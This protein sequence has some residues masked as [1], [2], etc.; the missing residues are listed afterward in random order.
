MSDTL[1]TTIKTIAQTTENGIELINKV[2]SFYN[3]AWDKLILVGTVA[4]GVIGILVPFVIQWYQKKTLKISEELMKKELENQ[5]LTLK[6]ELLDHININI[7]KEIKIFEEKIEKLNASTNAKAFHLQGNGQLANG[8]KAGALSDYI[9]SA[10]N[11]IICE[12]YNN[13]Q[14]VLRLI[15]EDCLPSLSLEEIEDLKYRMAV[16]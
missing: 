6:A 1:R 7:K 15:L 16:I 13:L 5:A 12:D 4:F 3:S 2:D 14:T 9:I 11:Y 10:D 8:Y